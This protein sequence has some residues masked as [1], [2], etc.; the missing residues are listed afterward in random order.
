MLILGCILFASD[1]FVYNSPIEPNKDLFSA[2]LSYALE[3]IDSVLNG[4]LYQITYASLSLFL[5]VLLQLC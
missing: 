3:K 4:E 2:I 1:L 5:M